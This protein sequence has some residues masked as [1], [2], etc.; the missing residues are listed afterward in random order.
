MATLTPPL[1]L[2]VTYVAV[3]DLGNNLSKVTIT[4]PAPQTFSGPSPPD[5]QSYTPLDIRVGMY[6]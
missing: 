4:I 1:C 2:Q 5:Q 3:E 6:L